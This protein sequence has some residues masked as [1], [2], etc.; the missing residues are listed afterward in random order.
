MPAWMTRKRIILLTILPALGLLVS[1]SL[2]FL[3][4]PFYTQSLNQSALY[5]YFIGSVYW[6]V[7]ALFAGVYM[8]SLCSS[9]DH[10][11]FFSGLLSVIVGAGLPWLIGRML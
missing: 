5:V 9:M 1:I 6:S 3:S 2:Q 10:A 8:Y 4:G 11:K 7:V